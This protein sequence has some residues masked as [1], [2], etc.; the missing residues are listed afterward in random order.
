LL[1]E[2]VQGV[3]RD[4]G[5]QRGDFILNVNGRPV[6]TVN[7]FREAVSKAGKAVALLVQRGSAQIFIP[8]RAE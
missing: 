5:V 7:E 8:V 1:V 3:A 4:A 6:K 2:R